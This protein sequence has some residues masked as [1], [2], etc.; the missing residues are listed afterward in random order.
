MFLVFN[1]KQFIINYLLEI[2]TK[3]FIKIF[4]KRNIKKLYCPLAQKTLFTVKINSVER[5][6]ERIF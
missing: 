4:K 5:K 3:I 6:S 1:E 2:L